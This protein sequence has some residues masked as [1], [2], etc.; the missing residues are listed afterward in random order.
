MRLHG[1]S[2]CEILDELITDMESVKDSDAA[3]FEK[4][5]TEI[6][7]TKEAEEFKKPKKG[8]TKT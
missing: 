1:I 6:K 8:K 3:A 4:M 2:D 5:I 7:N